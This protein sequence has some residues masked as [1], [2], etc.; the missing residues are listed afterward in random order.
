MKGKIKTARRKASR[1]HGAT[2]QFVSLV[3]AG[4]NE[5]PFTMI[6]SR[7]GA[8]AMT[9]KKRGKAKTAQRKSH[10][11]L[12][13]NK[14]SEAS[15]ETR[16]ETMIAKMV[17]DG[18]VF[19]NEDQ[20]RA[21]IEEAE[22]DAEDIEIVQNDDGSFEARSSGLTDDDFEKIGKVDTEEEGVEAFVGQREVEVEA[23]D[24]DDDE[25]EDDEEDD[26]EE[27]EE[28][29][30][31]EAE[32]AAKAAAA[33][34]AKSKAEP[35][36]T[37]AKKADDKKPEPLSKRAEFIKKRKEAQA[38]AETVAKFDAWDAKY[39]KGN[40]TLAET[41]KAGMQYDGTPPGFFEVQAAFGGA[42]SNIVSGD[43]MPEGNKQEALNKAAMEFAEII[44]ALDTYFDEFI[45]A[46]AEL[47]EKAFPEPE[48]REAIV[49]WAEG[50]GD[51]VAG[52]VP[53]AQLV[54]KTA[55]DQAAL[56]IDYNALSEG[57]AESIAKTLKPI[58]DKVDGVSE[59]VQAMSTRS[60]TK[61]AADPEDGGSA[62]DRTVATK[63]QEAAAADFG[64]RFLG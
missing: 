46:D 50:Y 5:T 31:D 9:I 56:A 14:K 49:K 11:P 45:N 41:I 63:K 16:T 19:E 47:V 42:I 61:K 55:N 15:V 48:K 38:E 12:S 3:D 34:K 8:K 39:S 54:A 43:G 24:A 1:L 28:E 29:E 27:E 4:A 6:K 22:W 40:N 30:D 20:V 58:M 32:T 64:K 62:G 10:K 7:N 33:K 2:A 35:K 60:P 21:Y 59:T 57:M 51:F 44:G 37:P 18:D 52:K 17:F 23:K 13:G 26:E 36:K 25:D 53:A